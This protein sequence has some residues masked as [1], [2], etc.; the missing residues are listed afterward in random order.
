MNK[1]QQDKLT[2]LYLTY[3]DIIKPLLA[4]IE[5]QYEKFPT[6]IYNELRSFTDHISRCY[7]KDIT[8]KEI[9]SQLE[10]AERHI[11]RI[12]LDSYKFLNVLYHDKIEKFEKETKHI[13]LTSISNGDFYIKYKNLKNKAIAQVRLAKRCEYSNNGI[14]YSEYEKAYNCF[15]ELDE[16]ISKNLTNVNWA[17]AKFYTSKII[18]FLGWIIALILT[19]VIKAN[20][21]KILETFFSFFS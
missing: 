21:E 7:N 15:I 3:L 17:K 10:K 18:S 5:S 6:P 11:H 12:I 14:D 2:K 8:D 1:E 4:E 16:F 13:D 9:N 19:A 20:N